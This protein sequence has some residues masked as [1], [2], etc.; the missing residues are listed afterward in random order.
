MCF[1]GSVPHPAGV[2]RALPR[3]PKGWERT[4]GEVKREGERMEDEGKEAW[5]RGM[6]RVTEGRGG[7]EKRKAGVEQIVPPALDPPVYRHL[8]TMPMS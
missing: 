4:G 6:G 1:L 2:L 7:K 8:P 5:V 3:P